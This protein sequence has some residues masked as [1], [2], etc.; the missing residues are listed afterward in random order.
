MIETPATSAAQLDT[1]RQRLAPLKDDAGSVLEALYVA[2][3]ILGYCSREAIEVIA[4]ELGY[5]EAHVFGVVTFYTMFYTEPQA[6]NIIRVC[7]DLSCHLSGAGKIV[8]AIEDRAGIRNGQAT[9]DGAVKLELVSCLGQC[10]RQPALLVG[11]AVHGPMTEQLAVDL[12][13]DLLNGEVAKD[14]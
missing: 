6:R 1:L 14:A 12:V 3:E 5:P 2:Q 13:G 8:R 10:D 9:P 4:A 7:R 11:L